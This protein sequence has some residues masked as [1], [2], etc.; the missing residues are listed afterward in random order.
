MDVPVGPLRIS[1]VHMKL[2]DSHS[3]VEVIERSECL[4]LLRSRA[5]GRLALVEGGQPQIYPVNYALDGEHVIFRTGD[6]TKF[7]TSLRGGA[8]SFEIDDVDTHTRNAWSVVVSGW[9][10]VIDDLVRVE[11][12]AAL[13]LHAWSGPLKDHWVAIT[14][15]RITGRRVAPRDL[16][17]AS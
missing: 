16:R 5:V 1:G 7:A 4:L 9:A 8:V 6:G 2:V 10:R 14:P 17:S 12:L 15:E 3:G 13:E 11:R